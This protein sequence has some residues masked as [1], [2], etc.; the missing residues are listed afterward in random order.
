MV[1]RKVGIV[2]VELIK[3]NFATSKHYHL[4]LSTHKKQLA[5]R[6]IKILNSQLIKQNLQIVKLFPKSCN[7]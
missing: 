5:T 2:N 3:G 7:S 6:K 4:K 1:I